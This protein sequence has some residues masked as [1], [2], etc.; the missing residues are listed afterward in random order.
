[1]HSFFLVTGVTE[2]DFCPVHRWSTSFWYCISGRHLQD[3][4]DC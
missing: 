1:M 2:V 3:N 4:F